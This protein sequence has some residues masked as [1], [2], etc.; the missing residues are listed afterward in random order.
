MS[1]CLSWQKIALG[2]AR[3]RGSC[4]GGNKAGPSLGSPGRPEVGI[5]HRSLV[6]HKQRLQCAKTHFNP[7]KCCHKQI[8]LAIVLKA[9]KD[10]GQKKKVDSLRFFFFSFPEMEKQLYFFPLKMKEN[11]LV[12]TPNY[13]I[14]FREIKKEKKKFHKC[15]KRDSNSWGY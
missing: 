13:P 7:H 4:S 10:F 15:C 14:P 8:R 9:E 3:H 5:L 12:L 11:L 1:P 2:T 6:F